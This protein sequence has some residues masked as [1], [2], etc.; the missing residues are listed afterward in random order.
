[1]RSD[2][3]SISV[4]VMAAETWFLHPIRKEVVASKLDVDQILSVR[5]VPKRTTPCMLQGVIHVV[6]V[7]AVR[8]RT[9]DPIIVRRIEIAS[10]ITC[11]QQHVCSDRIAMHVSK[12]RG[13][14]MRFDNR[15]YHV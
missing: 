11:A 8:E 2:C 4:N 10:A 9:W 7:T 14:T 1:M 6:R 13:P 5:Q 15:A 12:M 3:T